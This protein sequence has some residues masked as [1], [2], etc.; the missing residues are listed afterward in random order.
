MGDRLGAVATALGA[1]TA[2][3]ASAL[4]CPVCG[5]VVE[6]RGEAEPGDPAEPHEAEP[7]D[8]YV[9]AL[10]AVARAVEALLNSDWYAETTPSG[11]YAM[12]PHDAWIRLLH[13]RA[14][15]AALAAA[16]QEGAPR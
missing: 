5:R 4:I 8:P 12:V 1:M 6:V 2:P 11:D 10:E 7:K 13:A 16:R 9:A 15:V 14:A 3:P